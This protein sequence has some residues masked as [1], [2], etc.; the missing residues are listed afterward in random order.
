MTVDQQQWTVDG[1]DNVIVTADRDLTEDQVRDALRFDGR[2]L[3]LVERSPREAQMPKGSTPRSGKQSEYRAPAFFYM[4]EGL[5]VAQQRYQI[6]FPPAKLN[7]PGP[8]IGVELARIAAS[9]WT[10]RSVH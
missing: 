7:T 5:S 6:Q 9:S 10:A 4:R 3:A 1:M 8:K 2:V